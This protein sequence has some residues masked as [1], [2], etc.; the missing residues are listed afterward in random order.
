MISTTVELNVGD[1]TGEAVAGGQEIPWTSG[2][3]PVS[4]KT[5]AIVT[6]NRGDA[7][8]GTESNVQTQFKVH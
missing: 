6:V 8:D 1:A 7:H 2:S 4:S 3:S 5:N